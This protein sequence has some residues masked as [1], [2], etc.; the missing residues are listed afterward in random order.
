MSRRAC[1]A[2]VILPRMAAP[3]KDSFGP[4]VV[5][6]LA[7]ALAEVHPDLDRRRFIAEGLDG[8]H[9]L[10]LMARG[11]H[12]AAVMARHLPGDPA[13]AVRMVTASLGP[14]EH[15]LTGMAPFRYLPHV[16]FVATVGLGAF[17]ESM[18]AQYELTKRFTAEFSIRA[19]LVHHRDPTLARLRQWATDPDEDVR[20]L[21]S[22]G[23]RPRLPWAPRLPEFVAD[24]SPVLELLEVLRDDPS[25]YVRRS[26]ANNL[27]DI[28][29]DHPDLVVD[30]ARRWWRQADPEGR[31]MIR[32]ALRTLVKRADPG[33]LGVLGLVADDALE[34]GAVVVDPARPRIGERVRIRVEVTDRRVAGPLRPVA[35]DLVIHFVKA[36]GSTSPRVFKAGVRDLGPGRTGA[37]ALT[38]SLAQHTT[39]THRPGW[40]R[41]E[42]QVNGQRHEAGG[43]E[44]APGPPDGTAS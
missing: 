38:V 15:G 12:L 7:G 16:Q 5:Q 24:P 10:E 44:L 35:M 40:H 1:L 27:N 29:K 28:A 39:R 25:E 33:A 31:R 19:F 17:E 32:H 9:E 36:N 14:R 6:W 23:T 22:E 4:E 18:T 13:V 26:V 2:R 8:F 34:I 30:V 11:R 3:M 37:F 41:L 42:A 20:R 43:F 21:V